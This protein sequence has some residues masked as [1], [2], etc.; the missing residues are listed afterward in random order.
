MARFEG[1]G[2]AC[3]AYEGDNGYAALVADVAVDLHIG[4]GA[5]SRSSPLRSTAARS[6]IRTVCAT[7]WK[8]GILQGMSRALVEEVTWDD[9]AL[10]RWTG[11]AIR[12]FAWATRCRRSRRSCCAR[13]RVC[14]RRGRD[15]DHSHPGCDRQ[16]DLRRHGARCAHVPFTPARVLAAMAAPKTG[17]TEVR[18]R[19]LLLALLA[20]NLIAPYTVAQAMPADTNAS[21]STGVAAFEAIVPVLRH[22]RCIVCHST[23]DYPRQGDDL[24]RHIM[25]VR[26]GP[27]G[28]CGAGPLQ[29][30]SPGSQSA[31]CAHASGCIRMASTS[32]G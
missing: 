2:V 21:R 9:S 28:W 20:G 10:P 18:V 31:G 25:D 14:N 23:G 3:V 5:A 13:K 12:A 22:P 19:R 26:R 32:V 7:R 30:L 29:H 6:P 16:R 1:R 4:R 8:A 27:T 24:H 15:G 17:R 11:T